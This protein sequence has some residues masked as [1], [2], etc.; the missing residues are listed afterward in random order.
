MHAGKSQDVLTAVARSCTLRRDPHHR[1]VRG[2]STDVG[3]Q[4][5][6]LG[7]DALLIV[8]GGGN[9]LELESDPLETGGVGLGIVVHKERRTAEHHARRRRA[10]VLA[11]R[12]TQEPKKRSDDLAE[13]I[14]P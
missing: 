5:D 3:H 10:E 1:K 8:E 13:R 6:L 4:R 9:R 12:Y 7:L 11:S 2:T 14:A